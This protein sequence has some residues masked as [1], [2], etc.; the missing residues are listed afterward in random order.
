MATSVAQRETTGTRGAAVRS[1]GSTL[2]ASLTAPDV[3]DCAV[4]RPE[5]TKLIARSTRQPQPGAVSRAGLVEAAR[6][7]D[8]RLVAV[9]APAGYGKSMFLAEWAAAEDRR[10]VWVSLDRFDD[11]P[12]MLLASLASSYC[13]AGLGHA[14]L[15]DD[16]DGPGWVLGHATPRLAAGVVYTYT[17]EAVVERDGQN[18]TRTKT[19]QVRAGEETHVQL[20]FAAAVAQK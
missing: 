5:I 14:D 16:K 13:R 3:P 19:I 2:A 20:D 17:V 8:C 6:S 15:V 11:D 10:V 7:S 9:T 1:G 18:V 4:Q 12:A